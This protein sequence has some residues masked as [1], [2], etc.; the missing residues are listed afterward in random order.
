[1]QKTPP[2]KQVLTVLKKPRLY[3]KHKQR[4]PLPKSSSHRAKSFELRTIRE[5]DQRLSV[6]KLM[7]E[8]IRKLMLDCDA[9]TIQEEW[10]A[11]R[12]VYLLSFLETCEIEAME[13]KPMPWKLYSTNLIGSKNLN[14]ISVAECENVLLTFSNNLPGKNW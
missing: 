12:A 11:S 8:R 7:R 1:L 13:G 2:R 9:Q 6:V 5:A 4:L 3:G 14:L 10:L